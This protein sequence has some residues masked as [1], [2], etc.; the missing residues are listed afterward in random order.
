MQAITADMQDKLLFFFSFLDSLK[1]S[2]IFKA[3]LYKWN[4][5]SSEVGFVPGMQGW[6]NI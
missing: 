5:I 4:N 3:E 1:A 2:E 6:F